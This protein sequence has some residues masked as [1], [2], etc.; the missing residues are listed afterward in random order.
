MTEQ[1]AIHVIHR[2]EPALRR[3]GQQRQYGGKSVT[4][5]DLSVSDG[6][7]G[8]SLAFAHLNARKPRPAPGFLAKS[9]TGSDQITATNQSLPNTSRATSQSRASRVERA[10]RELWIY[11]QAPDDRAW[12]I[13]HSLASTVHRPSWQASRASAA[14][15]ARPDNRSFS[16]APVPQLACGE[17]QARRRTAVSRMRPTL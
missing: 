5:M 13:A 16:D 7:D 6:R 8:M 12:R 15:L 9:N 17:V 10:L 2:T 3:L 4:V 1:H 14:R 11:R